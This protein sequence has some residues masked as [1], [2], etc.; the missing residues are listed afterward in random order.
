MEPQ[1][2]IFGLL[3][4]ATVTSAGAAYFAYRRRG[5]SGGLFLALM[6]AAMAVW[7][8]TYVGELLADELTLKVLWARLKYTAALAIPPLWVIFTLDYTGRWRML[9]RHSGALLIIPMLGAAASIWTND[10]HGLVWR[11]TAPISTPVGTIIATP[12]LGFWIIAA[13]AYAMLAFGASLL[14]LNLTSQRSAYRGQF[15]VLM[16]AVSIPWLANA[17]SPLALT[18]ILGLDLTPLSFPLVAAILG[19]GFRRFSLMESSPVDQEEILDNLTDGVVAMDNNNCVLDMN[20]TAEQILGVKTAEAAGKPLARL[21][22][23]GDRFIQVRG[24]D[25]LIRRYTEEGRAH[26]EVS[27]QLGSEERHYSLVLTRM[28]VKRS[29]TRLLALRDTTEQ[30]LAE[31]RLDQ[32]AHHDPLTNLPNRRMF[33]DRLEEVLARSRSKKT[34]LALLFLD[35]DR[36]KH[37]ND[38]LGHDVGDLL[39]RALS[40]RLLS[41]VRESDTVSRLAGDEFVVLLTD[42]E[43]PEDAGKVA[44]KIIKAASEVY[45]LKEH[46]IFMT[47]SVGIC[48]YPRDGQ[49]RT[50]LLR[51]VDAAMYQAKI[52]GKNRFEFFR[53]EVPDGF[54][55]TEDIVSDI[56][57]ALDK[58]EFQTYYQ[59]VIALENGKVTGIEALARW[60]HPTRGLLR[61]KDFL[62]AAKESRLIVPIGTSVLEEASEQVNHWNRNLLGDPAMT[63]YINLSAGQLHH[64]GLVQ[65]ITQTL[66]KT[67]LAPEK[68]AIEISEPDL[69]EDVEFSVAVLERLKDVGVKLGVDDFG[70]GHLSLPN[71]NRF[72]MDFLKLDRTLICGVA[73]DP[74]RETMTSA[75][76]NLAHTLGMQVVAEGVETP[77]Q[78]ALLRRLGCDLLQGHYFAEALPAD[79]T[80][81]TISFINHY[82]D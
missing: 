82:Y 81:Q 51:N 22:T 5:R 52:K 43:D 78:L 16:T 27:L 62:A 49:D 17:L 67:G 34:K 46:E 3:A 32:L 80:S 53:E 10:L 9:N 48:I 75:I 71:L 14:A 37:I 58:E 60:Q 36:L 54:S 31:D 76:I 1:H 18:P 26:A 45:R 61:P 59:P 29:S 21:T 12:A 72:R 57:R 47:T 77:R 13:I 24:L 23:G 64:T 33:Y 11:Y 25:T 42:I 66:Q 38:T 19:L 30:K 56:T 41:C 4:I 28:G 40:E 55:D 50:T 68:L 20:P 63:A 79:Q 2:I 15:V 69:M 8:L 35:L 74:D 44:Q 70:T 6:L 65:D 39:L 7:A 73:D